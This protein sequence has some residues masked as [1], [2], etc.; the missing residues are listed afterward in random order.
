GASSVWKL[1]YAGSVGGHTILGIPAVRR[2]ARARGD[3]LKVWPFETGWKALNEAELTGVDVVVAEVYPSIVKAAPVSGEVRDLTQV[4]ALAEY[5]AKRD[6]AG[7]LGA[8][9]APPKA[10]AADVILDAE[11]E[12]GW[13]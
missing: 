4:R 10:T 11:R 12:E 7:T 3:K 8:L 5:L 6:E 2:L 9:F 1:A 13:M